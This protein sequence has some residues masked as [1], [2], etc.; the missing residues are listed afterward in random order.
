MMCRLDHWGA[1]AR[2]VVA[3]VAEARLK[4]TNEPMIALGSK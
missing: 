2:I 4:P 3:K 1:V